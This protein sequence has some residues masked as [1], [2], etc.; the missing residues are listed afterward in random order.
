MK[1]SKMPPPTN[2]EQRLGGDAIVRRYTLIAAGVGV[3][4][5]PT[6]NS[7]GIAVMELA[8]I[9]ELAK[10]YLYPFPTK[11]AATKAFISLVG[12]LGP[13]YLALKSK[14]AVSAVPLI[15]HLL[16]ATIYS[17]TGAVSVYAVGKVFQLHFESG[18]TLL[19]KENSFL[20]KIFKKEAQ[21]GAKEIPN[22]ISTRT[23]S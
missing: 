21:Q 17:V 13:V 1:S 6:V 7:V 11:L 18:G 12:S 15:G 5:S 16:S 2:Q 14:S 4:P 8:M 10:N 23:S 9:D 3:I 19:S 22:L 20:R